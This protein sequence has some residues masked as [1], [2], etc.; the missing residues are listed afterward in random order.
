MA[1]T[2][3][4]A[5]IV[6]GSDQ[7]SYRRARIEQ[8]TIC[9]YNPVDPYWIHKLEQQEEPKQRTRRNQREQKRILQSDLFLFVIFVVL[10]ILLPFEGVVRVV[11]MRYRPLQ[12]PFF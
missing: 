1:K 9:A 12:L 10:R 2:E 4:P 8:L 7:Y 6:R 3:A 11:R 5:T